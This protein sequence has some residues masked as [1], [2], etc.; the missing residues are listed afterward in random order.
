MVEGPAVVLRAMAFRALKFIPLAAVQPLLDLAIAAVTRRHPEFTA[1]LRGLGQPRYL[2]DPIDLPWVF[3]MSPTSAPPRLVAIPRKGQAPPAAAAIRAKFLTLIDLLEGRL[4]GDALFFS[5]ELVIEGD[6]EA[7]IALRN[8]IEDSEIGLIE[9]LL[10]P[11]PMAP[12]VG[13]VA[14]RIFVLARRGLEATSR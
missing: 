1:R 3:A 9:D 10:A 4:D 6:V 14:R 2:I 11:L 8:A 5:R 12:L 13:D 7:V